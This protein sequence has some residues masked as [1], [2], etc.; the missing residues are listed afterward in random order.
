MYSQV[1]HRI[2]IASNKREDQVQ[3]Q[4]LTFS[5]AHWL[6]MQKYLY[7]IYNIK[8]L[9]FPHLFLVA[10]T[11]ILPVNF[12]LKHE[13]NMLGLHSKYF[14]HFGHVV[15]TVLNAIILGC[16][17]MKVLLLFNTFSKLIYSTGK[18]RLTWS[19]PVLASSLTIC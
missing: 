16:S 8:W 10:W 17:Y 19:S 18:L 4:A 5:A 13:Q 6:F 12:S 9:T 11:Y 3:I 15:P 1:F 7:I 2:V 14:T